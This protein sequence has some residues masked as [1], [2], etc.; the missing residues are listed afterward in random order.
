MRYRSN[1]RQD[2]LQSLTILE[3][4]V[5]IYEELIL[6]EL[7]LITNLSYYGENSGNSVIWDNRLLIIE[8]IFKFVKHSNEVN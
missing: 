7:S 1:N 8:K 4:P 6:N 3:Y 2:I 5:E